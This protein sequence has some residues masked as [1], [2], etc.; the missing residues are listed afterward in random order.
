MSSIEF[1]K[2]SDFANKL[3][4]ESETEKAKKPDLDWYQEPKYFL[5]EIS[6]DRSWIN[7]PFFEEFD[8]PIRRRRPTMAASFQEMLMGYRCEEEREP[9]RLAF[10]YKDNEIYIKQ[11]DEGIEVEYR[12]SINKAILDQSKMI[13]LLRYYEYSLY[14][15]W[16]FTKMDG[17]I[18]K[19]AKVAAKVGV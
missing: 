9:V 3:L 11:N 16:L 2:Y 4:E 8:P 18:Y 10:A 5:M 14:G 6:R 17:G 7:K 19:G 12:Q 15:I 1:M 13:D